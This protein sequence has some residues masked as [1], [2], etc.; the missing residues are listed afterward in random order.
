ML[1]LLLAAQFLYVV[2][3]VVSVHNHTSQDS[4][5]IR[6][7]A[8]RDWIDDT[9]GGSVGI[10]QG[11]LNSRQGLPIFNSFADAATW[12]DVEFWNKDV[13]R[14]FGLPDRMNLTIGP[15]EPMRLDYATGDLR[16]GAGDRPSRLAV[17]TSDVRFAPEF[18][19]RPVSQGDMTLYDTPRPYRAGWATRGLDQY[20][21]T[22]PDGAT[23]RVFAARG[24]GSEVRR[25]TLLL[26]RPDPARPAPRFII[27]GGGVRRSAP[28]PRPVTPTVDVCVPAGGHVDLS[29]D[30]DRRTRQGERFVGYRVA[31][32]SSRPTGRGCRAS[33]N[34]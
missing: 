7:L 8:A 22:R 11:V 20:G 15:V 3:R 14:A 34:R 10:V 26:D 12:W 23:L 33:G 30:A 5:G 21:W 4:V 27:S 16:T 19:G 31:L 18:R 28:V 25:I 24:A 2:P 6:P 1:G 29:L 9:G 17:A 32:I 13:D